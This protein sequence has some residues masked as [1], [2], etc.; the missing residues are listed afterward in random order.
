MDATVITLNCIEPN[1]KPQWPSY[2]C[3]NPWYTHGINSVQ[4]YYV[5]K[6]EHDRKMTSFIS[7]WSFAFQGIWIASTRFAL[8][9]LVTEI[10]D[11][12]IVRS[13]SPETEP[14]PENVWK[15]KKSKK[16]KHVLSKKIVY[17]GIK[18]CSAQRKSKKKHWFNGNI[19]FKS[20]ITWYIVNFLN[21]DKTVALLKY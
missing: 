15:Q 10:P 1:T 20:F 19:V 18:L 12:L 7:H 16:L 3:P 9:S 2:V 14:E 13:V 11:V 6:L 4:P 8:A 5:T 21:A 17:L